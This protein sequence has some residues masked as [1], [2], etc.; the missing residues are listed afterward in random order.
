VQMPEMDGLEASRRLNADAD[1]AGRPHIV[2]MTAN[3][4]E[5]DREMCL[6]A[7]MDDYLTKPLRQRT[8][9]DALLRW[10][11][12]PPAAV[13]DPGPPNGAPRDDSAVAQVLDEAIIAEL[14]SLEGAVL[15]DLVALFFDEA[16]QRLSELG[17]AV[18]RADAGAIARMAHTLKGNSLT[19]GAGHVARIATELETSA[20]AGD[21][22]PAAALLEA[23]RG[24][25]E[26]A[27]QAFRDRT[28]EP[29]NDGVFSL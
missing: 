14:D 29:D 27:G 16:A 15:A 4:M 26:D 6:A 3:A 22:T 13:S 28:I 11:V 18:D 21:L 5:G 8:L 12:E 2:A 25:L 20:K 17:D 7:G 9:K 1:G 23:L 19:L 24:A 10:I